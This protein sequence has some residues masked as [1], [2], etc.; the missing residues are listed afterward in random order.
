MCAP[1]PTPRPARRRAA[2]FTLVELMV[3]VLLSSIV[4]ITV[5]FVFS[6]N[7]RQYYVQEQIVQ[8]QEGMRFALE[9]IKNDLRNTGRHSVVNGYPGPERDRH[10]CRVGTPRRAITLIESNLNQPRVLTANQN[11]L[12]PDR[13]QLLADGSM[14]IRLVTAQ[15][16]GNRVSVAAAGAQLTVDAQRIAGSAEHFAH[17]YRPGY[18]LRIELLDT[19]DFDLVPIIAADFGGGSPAI[20]LSDPPC[21]DT[22]ACGGRCLVNAVKLVEYAI[23]P[24][25]RDDPNAFKTDLVRRVLDA[26]NPARAIDGESLTIAEYAV[27]LQVWGT[28]DTRAVG[29]PEPTIPPD[30]NALDTIGNWQAAWA[31][32]IDESG[33]MN[34]NPQRLRSLHVLLMT[35]TPREDPEFRVAIDRDILVRN[36]VPADRTWFDVPEPGPPA[37]ARVATLTSEVETPNL[38]TF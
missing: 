11:G 26:R 30:P 22:T 34:A 29:A 6:A 2:G 8:M 35:R 7:A 24:D 32:F 38:V 19:G 25:P 27:D 4:L 21:I 36:R 18:F 33:A 16:V 10:Y 5:Y 31:G 17:T 9:Y 15:V 20:T 1:R 14:D 28:Y 12:Q 37:L 13:L 23:L 3:A